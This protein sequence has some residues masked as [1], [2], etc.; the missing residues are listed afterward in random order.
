MDSTNQINEYKN[1]E[2]NDTNLNTDNVIETVEAE[3]STREFFNA[4]QTEIREVLEENLKEQVN[5][6]KSNQEEEEELAQEKKEETNELKETDERFTDP[7]NLNEE[8]NDEIIINEIPEKK[9][10]EEQ[11][12]EDIV[13]PI[14][15]EEKSQVQSEIHNDDAVIESNVE[16]V[17]N[18]LNVKIEEVSTP[19]F[20]EKII[21]NPNTDEAA[22]DR[23]EIIANVEDIKQEQ[24]EVDQ[25]PTTEEINQEKD[26]LVQQSEE[27][28]E[29]VEK[30]EDKAEEKL[31]DTT[32][33]IIEKNVEEK[34]S[35]EQHN[36]INVQVEENLVNQVEDYQPE[37]TEIKVEESKIEIKEEA[38]ELKQEEQQIKSENHLNETNNIVPE[39]ETTTKQESTNVEIEVK[40]AS[41]NIQNTS[42]IPQNDS[43]NT[44]ETTKKVEPEIP[45]IEKES[46]DDNE[47]NVRK[48]LHEKPMK[49]LLYRM[50]NFKKEGNKHIN[51][52]SKTA[53]E[54]Y[55]KAIEE[56]ET[57][58]NNFNTKVLQEEE[59]T[60]LWSKIE[61][62]R[63]LIFSNLALFFERSKLYEEAISTDFIVKYDILIY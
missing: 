54:M 56:Y 59:E 51:S 28:H 36:V 18:Q 16:K 5:L 46:N 47:K 52:L 2:K 19:K 3:N 34:Q 20:D 8:R 31:K 23:P 24:I 33:D 45:V 63:K 55:R 21:E 14:V 57:F 42:E 32:D 13:N 22:E 6:G 40:E 49:D 39:S 38:Q 7:G 41:E 29:I 27:T 61:E 58:S 48:S 1:F 9:V 44:S 17:I 12:K 11:I 60:T 43:Q 30:S 4:N 10:E 15:T 53:E 50:I 26:L 35:D 37:V 62:E 25:I